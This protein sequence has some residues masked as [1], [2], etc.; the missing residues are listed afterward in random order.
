MKHLV[1]V[2]ANAFASTSGTARQVA[3]AL[4]DLPG[5]VVAVSRLWRN[6][7]WPPGSGPD[8]VNA[9]ALVHAPMPPEAMLVRL[10]RLEARRGRVRRVR[11]G[12][13]VL[14]LD[15]IGAEGLVRPDPRTVRRWMDLEPARQAQEAPEEFILPHPRLQDRS[16]VLIP[17]AEVVPKWRHP[18]TGRSVASMAASLPAAK[19]SEMRVIGPVDGVVSRR[20]RA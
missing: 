17:A 6:P 18:V 1:A 13:R 2:G 7:A 9:V 16:F 14:D 11:W 5:R 4:R 15:L 10:H 20:P 19:R 12:A 8:F 3:H